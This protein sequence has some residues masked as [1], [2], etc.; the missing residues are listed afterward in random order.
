MTDPSALTLRPAR[1]TD[2][3]RM[4][5]MSRDLVEAGLPW[6]YTPRRMAALINDADTQAVVACD[7]NQLMG[8]ALMQVLDEHG[9]LSLLCVSANQQ[10]Q[11]IGRRLALWLEASARVAGLGHITLELRADNAA[12]LA[13][14]GSLGFVETQQVTGYYE[15]LFD[16]RRMQRTLRQAPAD[17]SPPAL[18]P[19]LGRFMKGPPGQ[20]G[21]PQQPMRGGPGDSPDAP[22]T[23]R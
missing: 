15:G 1:L 17:G 21:Q 11:G 10:R 6:R 8:L 3:V 13:F 14:Y 2:A 18:Q 12:A 7:H 20:P 22:A 9:H 16:A 4:A 5:A 19:D 23:G